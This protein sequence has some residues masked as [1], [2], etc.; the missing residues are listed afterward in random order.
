MQRTLKL[1]KKNWGEPEVQKKRKTTSCCR[2]MK[3]SAVLDY[4]L[5]F[6]AQEVKAVSR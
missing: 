4:G 5:I 3:K 6:I 1:K 2:T